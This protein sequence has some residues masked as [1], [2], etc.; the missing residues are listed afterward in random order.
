MLPSLF[1][2]FLKIVVVQTII[3]CY[4]RDC[5]SVKT[6]SIN[7]NREK[8]QHEWLMKR[9]GMQQTNWY[10]EVGLRGG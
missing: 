4:K 9:V 2:N 1:M 5:T 8:F 6:S 10:L 7:E 3:N